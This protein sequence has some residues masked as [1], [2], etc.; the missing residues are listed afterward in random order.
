MLVLTCAGIEYFANVGANLAK[1]N[2][3]VNG[4]CHKHVIKITDSSFLRSTS[5]NE[6]HDVVTSLSRNEV[7][8]QVEYSASVLKS[9]KLIK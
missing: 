6:M 9:V 8:G 7:P 5:E 3:N 1:Q 4:N 2:W